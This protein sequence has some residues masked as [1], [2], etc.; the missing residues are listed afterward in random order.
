MTTASDEL[1]SLLIPL[2]QER[3]ILPRVCVAEVVRYA[4]LQE[5]ES[6]LPWLRGH[7][8]WNGLR[9][10]APPRPLR[11]PR[12]SSALAFADRSARRW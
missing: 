8:A 3:L 7:I 6:P 10:P 12:F 1:Y 9:V 5:D 11:A 4:P 2:N